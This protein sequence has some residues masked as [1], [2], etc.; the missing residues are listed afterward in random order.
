MPRSC[1]GSQKNLSLLQRHNKGA[2]AVIITEL[3]CDVPVQHLKPQTGVRDSLVTRNLFFSKRVYNLVR[4]ICC[5]IF[6]YGA[7]LQPSKYCSST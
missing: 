5:V 4:K 2:L 7:Q 6:T 3:L 1:T